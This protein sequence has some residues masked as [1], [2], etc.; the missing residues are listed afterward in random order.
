MR[1][2]RRNDPACDPSGQQADLARGW[3]GR[4]IWGVPW[5]LLIVGA[6]WNALL[7]WLWIPGFVMAGA[8]CAWNAR[9]C[10]RLHCYVTGPLY[11]LAAA[12]LAC[13]AAGFIELRPGPF[14]V[15]VVGI[16]LLAQ[17][18]ERPFGRYRRR[19][20]RPT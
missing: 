5:I 6:Y 19:T 10:G 18:A 7:Y 4:V 1:R 20:V 9:R 16:S 13:A 2:P 14:L 3:R 15:V 17:L 8:A 11:L 12:C